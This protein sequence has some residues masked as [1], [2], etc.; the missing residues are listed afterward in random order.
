[1]NSDLKIVIFQNMIQ[2]LLETTDYSLE[3]IANLSNV[4][5]KN[6][7]DLQEGA[8]GVINVRRAE[9]N[10]LK[11]FTLI[12]DMEQNNLWHNRQSVLKQIRSSK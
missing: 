9:I 6:L 8:D 1:M 4:S 2:Y 11:L 12:I 10:V 3:R 5:L 7:R